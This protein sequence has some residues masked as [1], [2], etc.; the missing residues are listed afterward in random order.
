MAPLTAFLRQ[1]LRELRHSQQKQPSER[2]SL[3]GDRMTPKLGSF[4]RQ[5]CIVVSLT[6]GVVL[7]IA[8]LS[9]FLHD[10]R[11]SVER[12]GL[13]ELAFKGPAD[14]GRVQPFDVVLNATF[15]HGSGAHLPL[16]VGGFFDGGDV[17]KLRFSPPIEGRWTYI[18]QSSAATLDGRTGALWVTSAPV[19]SHG[20]VEARGF[21]LYHA[22]GSAHHSVG[23]TAYAWTSQPLAVQQQTIDTLRRSA[24]FSKIRMSVFPKRYQYNNANPVEVG[25]PYEILPGSAAAD[26]AVWGCVGPRCPPTNGSFHLRR[27]NVTYWQNLERRIAELR[28]LGIVADLILFHPYDNGHWGF[29]C[30][31][32]HDPSMYDTAN[33]EYYL[34]YVTARL[35]AYSN[36]WWSMANEWGYVKCKSSGVNTAQVTRPSLAE[37]SPAPTWDR[38]FAHLRARDPYRRMASIHNAEL[39]YDH[40]H[41]WVS[42]ISLQGVMTGVPWDPEGK[43]YARRLA[44]A[45]AA[46]RRR[47]GKP[48]V[49][50]EVWYEGN[51]PCTPE[52]GSGC[53]WG[54]LSGQAMAD[55][56]WFGASVGAYVGHGETL[57]ADARALRHNVEAPLW[58]AKGGRLLGTSPP[59]IRWYRQVWAAAGAD[60]GS[61]IPRTL[62]GGGGD[63]GGGRAAA[64]PNDDATAPYTLTDPLGGLVFAHMPAA[65]RW[66]LPL[67]AGSPA[68]SRGWRVGHL[69]ISS[70]RWHNTTLPLSAEHAPIGCDA[71]PCNV[72]VLRIELLPP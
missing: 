54:A 9:P 68:G 10:R 14:D 19:G 2:D 49:W 30:M 20:P 71:P 29:D 3:T 21:G 16:V 51:M 61:L 26:P 37:P 47:Y 28:A 4:T 40:G 58:W 33:D 17:Y 25:A 56:F 8:T 23:T 5:L 42:H 53:L 15:V 34:S 66:Q 50:D 35:A 18:T 48:V 32:G 60:F 65:G 62:G 67:P 70:R 36:V 69:N 41:P 57:G 1:G 31:G 13:F 63:V 6:S 24:A 72:M 22:D 12:W 55:R 39:L 7:T 44:Q 11:R 27:F 46:L 59:M 43:G 38:L 45:T 64:T 52:T